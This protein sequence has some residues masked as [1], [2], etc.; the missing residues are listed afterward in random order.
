MESIKKIKL[1]RPSELNIN[2][3]YKENINQYAKEYYYKKGR[4]LKRCEHCC[5][6]IVSCNFLKHTKTQ[7]HI[8]KMNLNLNNEINI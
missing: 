8:K 4:E 7:A 3:K 6:E 1:G 2:V 5:R